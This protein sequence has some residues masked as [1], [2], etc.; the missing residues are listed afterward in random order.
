MSW[1]KGSVESDEF[2]KSGEFGETL[3]RSSENSENLPKSLTE[4]N[5]LAQRAPWKAAN[6]AKAVDLAKICHRV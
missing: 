2:G 3:S 1:L 6:L 4:A 5:E